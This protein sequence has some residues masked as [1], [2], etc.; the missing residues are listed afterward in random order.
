MNTYT[1]YL[2]ILVINNDT[3]NL[4]NIDIYIYDNVL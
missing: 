3:V 1:E 4:N 2:N